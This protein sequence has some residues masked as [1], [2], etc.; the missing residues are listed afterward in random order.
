MSKSIVN[1]TL[2]VVAGVLLI[3]SMF[4]A[5]FVRKAYAKECQIF[6]VCMMGQECYSGG[7]CGMNYDILIDY[8]I[9]HNEEMYYL[10]GSLCGCSDGQDDYPSE[11][12]GECIGIFFSGC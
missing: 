7:V 6:L 2:G 5:G 8:Y 11:V 12:S 4:T 10:S 3:A 1:K 9:E